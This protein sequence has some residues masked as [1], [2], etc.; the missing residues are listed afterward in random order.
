MVSGNTFMIHQKVTQALSMRIPSHIWKTTAIIAVAIAI[1]VALSPEQPS[2]YSSAE[3]RFVEKSTNGMQ[4]VPASCPSNPHSSGE[5]S[6]PS[7]PSSGCTITASPS[8]ITSGQSSVIGWSSATSYDDPYTRTISPTIGSVAWSGTWSVAPTQTTTYTLTGTHNS[9]GSNYSCSTTVTVTGGTCTP[10]YYCTGNDL[11]YTNASCS[12]SLVQAC[13]W[14][15]S[16]GACLVPPEPTG[17]ITANPA[18]VRSGRTSQITWEAN[19]VESCTVTEDNPDINDSWTG[20]TG[21]RTSSAITQLTTYTLRC[22]DLTGEEFL[23]YA[24]VNVIPIWEEQ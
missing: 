1:V 2:A 10:Q 18:L 20:A 13:A 9:S 21:T 17:E 23:D 3:T 6:P 15:C 24:K 16:Y 22:I 5:C 8:S 11:Y 12:N 7:Q 19:N 4:I 14:G